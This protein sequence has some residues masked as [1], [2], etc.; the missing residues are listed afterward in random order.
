[1]C[2][3]LAHGHVCRHQTTGSGVYGLHGLGFRVWG[4]GF[5]CSGFRV[6]GNLCFGGL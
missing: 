2:V 3:R 5:I 4:M 6:T 1:M